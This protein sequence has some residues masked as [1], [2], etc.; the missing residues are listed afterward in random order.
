MHMEVN[1]WD[2]KWAMFVR[3]EDFSNSNL[4]AK[5]WAELGA[6]VLQFGLGLHSVLPF[7]EGSSQASKENS[8][9]WNNSLPR[10]YSS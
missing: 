6:T 9:K 7:Q 3:T 5:G 10:S 2:I 1:S 4:S 8:R